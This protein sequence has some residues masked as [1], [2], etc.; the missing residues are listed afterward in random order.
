MADRSDLLR[1]MDSQSP[2]LS[3]L[4]EIASEEHE[5]ALHLGIES[6][7][8]ERVMDGGDEMGEV[9]LHRL[10]RYTAGRGLEVEVRCTSDTVGWGSEISHGW[11]FAKVVGVGGGGSQG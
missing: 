2:G 6:L 1:R 8:G 9:I 3:F 10:G 11:W 5:E 4:S 7:P